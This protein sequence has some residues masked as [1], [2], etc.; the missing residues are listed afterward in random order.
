MYGPDVY[1]QYY[2]QGG[3]FPDNLPSI[4]YNQW[5]FAE[6]VHDQRAVVV[7]E[8]GGFMGRGPS[9]WRDRVWHDALVDFLLANCLVKRPCCLCICRSCLGPTHTTR[10]TITATGGHV[11]LDRQ[12][13]CA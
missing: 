6:E 12:P 8:W 2:F 1:N 11:L 9:G 4:W 10:L 3:G 13:E 7:G 5:G